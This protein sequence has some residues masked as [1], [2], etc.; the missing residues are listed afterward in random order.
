VG[1]FR[2]GQRDAVVASDRTDV[3]DERWGSPPIVRGLFTLIGVAAAGFLIW[4]ATLFDLADTGEYWAAMGLL[5]AAGLAMALSQL[6]GGWTKWGFPTISP[7]VLLLGF[8]P[9]LIAVGGILIATRPTGQGTGDEVAGWIRDIGLGGLAEDLI[10]FQGVLAFALGLVLGFIFDT[11]PRR[12]VERE[13]VLDED[14]HDYD[15][16]VTT[17]SD[18]RTVVPAAGAARDREINDPDRRD[19]R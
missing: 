14:V 11:R 9:A 5:A 6:F 1:I 7:S 17:R 15:R 2:R 12:I 3:G 16:P 19:V 4:L 10:V 18:E 8:V 13:V